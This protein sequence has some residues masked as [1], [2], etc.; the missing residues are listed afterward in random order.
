MTAPIIG[1]TMSSSISEYGY[2]VLSIT[3]A[4]VRALIRAGGCPLMIPL[5]LPENVL[6][7]LLPKLNGILFSGGGDVQPERYGSP[8]HPLVSGV[9]LDRDRVEIFL[10]LASMKIQLPILGI[11][12]GF[13]VINVALGGNLF[14]DILDQRPA[15]LRHS[16]FPEK[17]R[18]FLAHTVNIVPG[19][20]LSKITEQ[21]D[22][23]VNSLHHQ[24]IK[25]LAP[26]LN[27]TAFAP[28]GLIEAFEIFD[29]KFGLAVQWHPEWLP[30]EASMDSIFH[31][32]IRAAGT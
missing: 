31:D 4:Y 17:P 27:A 5:G 24:G 7:D 9:D 11:C 30:E 20:Q 14:E 15:S 28:D 32:L 29:Y 12:R 3:E 8:P 26:G 6:E 1:V 13:Q 23:L 10:V 22:A 16:Y 2:P 25:Q 18:N 19:S 21:S